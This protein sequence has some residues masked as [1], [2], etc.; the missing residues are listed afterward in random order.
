M[1]LD[2]VSLSSFTEH[3]SQRRDLLDMGSVSIKQQLGSHDY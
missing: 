3:Y 2:V 1:V